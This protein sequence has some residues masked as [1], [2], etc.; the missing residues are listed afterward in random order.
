MTDPRPAELALRVG[1]F[2]GVL[3]LV[4]WMPV[5]LQWMGAGVLIL[6]SLAFFYEIWVVRGSRRAQR[7]SLI[8]ALLP[9]GGAVALIQGWIGWVATPLLALAAVCIGLWFAGTLGDSGDG[10]DQETLH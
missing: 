3:G 9:L 7:D 6:V 8:S 2:A 4:G 1:I 10:P 5:N